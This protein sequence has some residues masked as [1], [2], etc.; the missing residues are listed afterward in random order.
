M[1]YDSLHDQPLAG[2]NVLIS[3]AA[4]PATTDARGRYAFNLDSI[5]EGL[6]SIGFF[7]PLLDSLGIAAP[8]KKVSTKRGEPVSVDLAVPSAATLLAALCPDST[9][10]GKRGILMGVVRDAQTEGALAGALIVVM[11]TATEIGN[12]SISK[13]PQA[14]NTRSMSDG[15][16]RVCGVPP[17]LP[18]RAQA[19]LNGKATGWIDM[20][21]PP[22]RLINRGFLVGDRPQTV[23]SQRAAAGTSA[24]AAG[25]A[26]GGAPTGGAAAPSGAGAA[27]AAA[28]ARAAGTP[29]PGTVTMLIDSTVKLGDAVLTGTVVGADGNP[30]EGAQVLLLGST[31]GAH[32]DSRG[33]FHLAGL[34]AGTQTF[35]VRLLSYLPRRY[36]VDLSAKHEN[37]LA[38]TLDSRAT[39]L[40]QV[41]VKAKPT[42]DMAGFEERKK[43]GLGMYITEEDIHNK[44]PISFSDI[45][46][47]IPGVSVVFDGSEYFV[48]I[49]RA[50]TGMG[51]PVA[52][53]V[54]GSPLL[55][56]SNDIDAMF[57]PADIA[58]IE[59]YRSAIEA[60]VQYQVAD[61]RCGVIVVWTK[62]VAGRSKPSSQ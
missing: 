19:R 46:R 5:P 40:S 38:A 32:A 59:I 30:L 45:F 13:I 43:K 17:G 56:A 8:P 57:N 28:G 47:G 44:A 37:T 58:A 4:A 1:V 62:R 36:T 22:F 50:V 15:S 60:P 7:H 14:L 2:A 52:W 54:D 9:L 39:V 12:S 23:A 10:S 24:A 25:A 3:G 29:P 21:L 53:I 16:Y 48:Q 26:T 51:C 33:R 11:W 42:G 35:E 49:T 55:A 27:P 6:H 31:L 18:F 41:E 20:E 61:S 34:P